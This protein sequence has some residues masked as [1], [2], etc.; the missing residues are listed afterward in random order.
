MDTM[1]NRIKKTG[2]MATCAVS[3]DGDWMCK[4]C[5]LD[6]DGIKCR[7]FRFNRYCDS[8]DAYYNTEHNLNP[9]YGCVKPKETLGNVGKEQTGEA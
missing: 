5:H 7:A 3:G 9:N 8:L 4:Y 6:R 1:T 2:A